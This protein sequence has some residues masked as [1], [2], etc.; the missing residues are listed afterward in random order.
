MNNIMKYV[1][2]LLSLLVLP[3][4][5]PNEEELA[6]TKVAANAVLTAAVQTASVQLTELA[7][8]APSETP[9]PSQTPEPSPTVHVNPTSIPY[10]TPQSATV[11]ANTNVRGIPS[12][13]KE[14]YL[15]YLLKGQSVQVLARN[16][17]ATWLQVVFAE[18]TDGMGWVIIGAIKN[19]YDLTTLPIMMFPDGKEAPGYLVP[20]PRFEMTGSPLPPGTPPPGYALYGTLKND[21]FVR[22]GPG[23]GFQSLEILKQGQLVSFNGKLSD[24][25]WVRIDYPSGPDGGGWVSR[26][27]VSAA[28][29]YDGLDEYDLMGN[30]VKEGEMPKVEPTATLDPNATQPAVI[31]VNGTLS[32]Q[33]NVRQGP[34]KETPSL[35]L[36]DAG[37]K[38]VINGVSVDNGWYR[39]DYNGT[40]GW[41]YAAYVVVEG[42]MMGIKVYNESGQ[43]FK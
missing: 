40:P 12:K 20:A 15:G 9:V 28:N 3:S 35:G 43:P 22:I 41:L 1:F 39:I 26:S 2:I 7:F 31:T 29:G 13:S 33:L 6:A 4:C 37:A 21:S 24:S 19:N 18:S 23:A 32:A 42:E 14:D 17:E 25:D 11:N 5:G 30:F 16:D 10:L 27:L 38:V 8:V 34:N 36:L